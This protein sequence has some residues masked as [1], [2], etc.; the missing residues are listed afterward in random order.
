MIKTYTLEDPKPV[1]KYGENVAVDMSH[2]GGSGVLHGKI[3]GRGI[4]H[5]IDMWMVEFVTDFGVSYPY[6]VTLIPHT[7]IMRSRTQ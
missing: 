4:V 5:V 7:A 2:L 3:V 1:F 6:H